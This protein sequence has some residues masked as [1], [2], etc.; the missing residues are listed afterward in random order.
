[1][2]AAACCAVVA[3][4]AVARRAGAGSVRQVDQCCRSLDGGPEADDGYV[5]RTRGRTVEG[6]TLYEDRDG[7]RRYSGADRV[8][9]LRGA[10]PGFRDDSVAGSI[11]ICC[12]DLDGEGLADDGLLVLNGAAER[13]VL[14]GIFEQRDAHGAPPLR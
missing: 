13:V 8:L 3:A 7:D 4:G 6:L 1:M 11:R 9:L 5:V 2:V 12:S 10:T 14:A